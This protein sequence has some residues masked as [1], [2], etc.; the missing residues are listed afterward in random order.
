LT[1]RAVTPTVHARFIRKTTTRDKSDTESSFTFRLVASERTGSQVRQI[2]LLNLPRHFDLPQPDLPQPDWPQPDWPQP[3][4][5]RLCSRIGALL[6][7]QSGMLPEPQ[8]VEVLAQRFTARL[9]AAQPGSGEPA[10]APQSASATP[11]PVYA[12]VDSHL[13]ATHSAVRGWSGSRRSR[14]HGLAGDQP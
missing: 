1:P 13:S 12:E 14:R 6:A 9:I 8:A 11:V 7:R 2:T 5:P 3:D 4:W 10:A